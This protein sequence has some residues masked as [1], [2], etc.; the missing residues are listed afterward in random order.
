MRVKTLAI[1][2][3]AALATAA[4]GGA[5]PGGE[6]NNAVPGAPTA[7]EQPS[8]SPAY[9]WW[10]AAVRPRL[11]PRASSYEHEWVVS[12]TGNDTAPGTEAAPLRTISRA[13]AMAKPGHRIRVLA[14]TYAERIV[15]DASAPA[16][17][18]D[19]PSPW[20]AR[21]SRASSRATSPGPRCR[22]SAPIGSSAASTST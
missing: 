16:G 17:T 21:A 5:S 4:C 6:P 3:S 19:A 10:R 13:I 7:G 12:P 8:A 9:S 14:G 1:L 11:R 20:R 15:L 22:W 2:T 18:A